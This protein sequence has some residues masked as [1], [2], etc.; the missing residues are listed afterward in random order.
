MHHLNRDKADGSAV[1]LREKYSSIFSTKAGYPVR[2][3]ASEFR[4]GICIDVRTR[5]VVDRVQNLPQFAYCQNVVGICASIAYRLGYLRLSTVEN[6]KGGPTRRG[7]LRMSHS[8]E[9]DFP[10]MDVTDRGAMVRSRDDEIDS[11]RR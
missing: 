1:L 6:K 4:S 9:S 2:L 3:V 10:A 5:L 8:V 11:G 7:D